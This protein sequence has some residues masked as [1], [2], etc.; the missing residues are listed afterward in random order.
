MTTLPIPESKKLPQSF[1]KWNPKSV[2]EKPVADFV[3]FGHRRTCSK[4]R[5]KYEIQFLLNFNEN[6]RKKTRRRATTREKSG[7]RKSKSD[8]FVRFRRRRKKQKVEE[9]EKEKGQKS[10]KRKEEKTIKSGIRRNV[11][12]KHGHRDDSGKKI[13]S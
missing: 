13:Q 3:R 10:E 2:G 7:A 8:D 4:A 1:R 6:L 11:G 9:E 12:R 5:K